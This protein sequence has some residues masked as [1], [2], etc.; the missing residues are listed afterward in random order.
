MNRNFR[1]GA[2]RAML[3]KAGDLAGYELYEDDKTRSKLSEAELNKFDQ[4]I[5]NDCE[6]VIENPFKND[7][8]LMRA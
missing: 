8:V 4:W 1:T 3:I 2:E 5:L 7:V 6:L